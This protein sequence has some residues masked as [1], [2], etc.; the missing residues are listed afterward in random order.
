VNKENTHA[1]GLAHDLATIERQ[2]PGRRKTLRMLAS[3]GMIILVPG[4]GSGSGTVD[5]NAA[6]ASADA[7]SAVQK[8]IAAR[9]RHT[10]KSYAASTGAQ[11]R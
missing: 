4:C 2:W 8:R 3:T 6:A 5:S 7:S 11:G 1:L 9:I 10:E